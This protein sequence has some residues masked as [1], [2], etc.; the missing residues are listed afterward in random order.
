MDAALAVLVKNPAVD[1]S[2]TAVLWHA[3]YQLSFPKDGENWML[4]HPDSS[5]IFGFSYLEI[6]P[7]P[8]DQD[9]VFWS[10]M[11]VALT[12]NKRQH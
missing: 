2:P 7:Q 4:I 10:L 11:Q 1:E 5:K 9:F 12:N 8:P 6:A 3:T